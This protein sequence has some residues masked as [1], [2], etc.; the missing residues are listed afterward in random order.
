VWWLVPLVCLASA[1]APA[2]WVGVRLYYDKAD[3][4]P[5][6]VL[7]NISYDPSAPDD[8]KRQLDAYV[9]QGQDWPVVVFIHGGGWAWGDRLQKFGGA[10]V[11]GNIG[12]FLAHE[13]IGA[14]VIS[15]RLVWKVSWDTQVEDVARAV[16]WAQQQMIAKGA[17]PGAVFLMG[18]SAGAQLA[19]R[20]ATDPSWLGNAGGNPEGICGVVAVS[21]AAYDLE[22]ETTFKLD[23]DRKYYPQRFAYRRE[24]P[25]AVGAGV[26]GKDIYA[27]S[28]PWRR[29]ASPMRFLDATDPPFLV[30]LAEGDYPSLHRQARLLSER[31]HALSL[32]RGFVIVP[33]VDHL[34][35]VLELSRP[36]HTAGR[37]ILK[38]F[39]DTPCPRAAVPDP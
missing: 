8:P 22:D 31:L 19:M 2:Y 17:R 27:L 6:Q 4:P 39:R 9:P 10:D 30:Q 20:I 1:C 16:A 11:Y 23:A 36:D 26:D 34:R 24:N 32:D 33:G 37:A 28:A 35:I 3:L 15:Y 25:E 38:F 13:G 18:H 14:V 7:R 5:S 12:R 29:T 21:G